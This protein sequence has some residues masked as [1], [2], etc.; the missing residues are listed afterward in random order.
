M[1]SK[2]GRIIGAVLDFDIAVYR[3]AGDQLDI[4]VES[5]RGMT[6]TASSVPVSQSSIILRVMQNP[7]SV[8]MSFDKSMVAQSGWAEPLLFPARAKALSTTS[9][10][11]SAKSIDTVLRSSR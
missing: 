7:L 10:G 3:G 11:V 9:S 4:R 8:G 6:A 1:K 5:G 2:S